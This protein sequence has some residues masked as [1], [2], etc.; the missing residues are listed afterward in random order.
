[1]FTYIRNQISF[2]QWCAKSL[3]RHICR[4]IVIQL[5]P[6]ALDGKDI[7]CRPG[8][9]DWA[10]LR[11]A[12]DDQYHLPPEQCQQFSC[13]VDLG[14]NVGYTAAHFACLYPHSRIVAVEMDADNYEMA[15][16]NT[17]HW[18]ERI[19]LLHA[20]IWTTDG[21]VTYSS[22]APQDAYKIEASQGE[23]LQERTKTVPA[24]SMNKLI[25]RFHLK[26]I[27]YLKVD[28][29]GAESELFL[30]A[31]LD[32]LSIVETLKIEIHRPQDMD[33]YYAVLAKA[34]FTAYKDNHHWSTISAFRTPAPGT[35]EAAA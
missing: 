33:K 10:T 20:A 9:T 2:F 27:D 22:D 23:A 14:A 15:T 19:S 17:R 16:K 8:T 7:Y 18:Q 1:M 31:P 11:S 21:E 3:H 4:R 32:W 34:G 26:Q 28:I 13:I 5:H 35:K 12:F 30:A 24:I 29:E 25:E 6:K